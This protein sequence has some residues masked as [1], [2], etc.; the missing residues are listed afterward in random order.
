MMKTAKINHDA[1]SAPNFTGDALRIKLAFS[2]KGIYLDLI[3]AGKMWAAHS[4]N[5]GVQ[6]LPL[7]EQTHEQMEQ[8]GLDDAERIV[9][10]LEPYFHLTN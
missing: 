9:F 7:P 1:M 5:A 8:Y 10:E 4:A 6:W 3:D 2:S